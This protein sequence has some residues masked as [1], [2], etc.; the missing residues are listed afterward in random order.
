MVRGPS[1]IVSTMPENTTPI[2]KHLWYDW[3]QQQPGIE[4]TQAA[5]HVGPGWAKLGP[6][7]ALDGPDWGPFGN[8]ALVQILL[9]SAG[10]PY[11]RLLRSAGVTED[12]FVTRE[13]HQKPPPRIKGL[14][15]RNTHLGGW[16]SCWW[17]R[18]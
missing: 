15:P 12:L 7:W 11:R 4:P 8:A 16:L 18:C 9:V 17:Q 14:E 6:K 13:L 1:L 5:F 3:T 10:S 2:F